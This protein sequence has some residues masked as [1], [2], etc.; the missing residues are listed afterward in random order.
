[1]FA[2]RF[3]DYGCRTAHLRLIGDALQGVLGEALALNGQTAWG[4]QESAAWAWFWGRVENAMRV[5][6]DAHE[7][8]YADTVHAS[9]CEIH[10]GRTNEEFGNTFYAEMQREAP[11]LLV[12]FVRPK[13]LQYSTFFRLM[14]T[15]VQFAQDPEDFYQQAQP[16]PVCC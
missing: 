3:F 10:R 16:D 2:S 4:A 6:V 14:E 7:R 11:E 9:W 5:T 15:L 1:M 8:D 13:S 12:L